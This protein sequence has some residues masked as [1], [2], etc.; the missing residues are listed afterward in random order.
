MIDFSELSLETFQ[1]LRAY[2]KEIVLYDENG[3]RVFEPS[4][5]RRFYLSGDNILVSI[6]EDGDNSAVK[7]YLSTNIQISEVL[8][9]VTVLRRIA[10]QFNVLFNVRKYNKKIEPKDFAT[11]AA[12]NEQKEYNMNIMEGLYGTSKSSYLKLEN[13]RMIVRHSARVKENMIG[14]RGRAIQSIFVE[15]AKGERFLFPVNVLSGARAMTQHVNHGGTFA[16]EVGQQI[17]R[18]AQDFSDLSKVAGHIGSNQKALPVQALNVRESIKSSAYDIRR[19]FERMCRDEASYVRESARITEGTA[20]NESKENIA[21]IVEALQTLLAIGGVSMDESALETV[22]KRVGFMEDMRPDSNTPDDAKDPDTGKAAQIV[23]PTQPVKPGQQTNQVG[24]GDQAD[25]DNGQDGDD[26][27]GHP[28]EDQDQENAGFH[29]SVAETAAVRAFDNWMSEFDP[30]TFFYEGKSFKRNKDEDVADKK[31]QDKQRRDDQKGKKER[32]DESSESLAQPV[33][34]ALQ[35]MGITVD[36]HMNDEGQVEISLKGTASS[37]QHDPNNR[38]VASP[39]N[40]SACIDKYFRSYRAAGHT[41]TQPVGGRFI[42]GEGKSYKRNKDDAVDD[43]KKQ[44]K[45]RR[46]DQKSKQE[47][48]DEA[49]SIAALEAKLKKLKKEHAD[50]DDFPSAR[51]ELADEIKTVEAALKA[52]KSL[53]EGKSFKRNEDEDVADKKKQDQDR[54]KARK[55]DSDPVEESANYFIP[56]VKSKFHIVAGGTGMSSQDDTLL[57]QSDDWNKAKQLASALV[58][59]YGDNVEIRSKSGKTLWAADYGNYDDVSSTGDIAEGKSF[60][61]NKDE[62]AAD[63]KKQD[64]Q[65]R[66]DQKNK[67]D[68]MDESIID[69]IDDD[70]E[71]DPD[72]VYDNEDEIIADV[73]RCIS[74]AR[75]N[76]GMMQQLAYKV[77]KGIRAL[78]LAGFS[79]MDV[80]DLEDP[81]VQAMGIS[82]SLEEGKSFKR[83]KDE[84]ADDKK[85]QDKQRRD[86]QRGKNE[87]VEEGKTF[88]RNKDEDAADK[89][90]QDQQKR[91]AAK[92]KKRADESSDIG[93]NDANKKVHP[94]ETQWHYKTLTD[95][96][97][98]PETKE[99]TGFVRKYKYQH[100]DGR[101]IVCTTGASADYWE[102]PKTK[103]SGYWGELENHVSQPAVQESPMKN[104]KRADEASDISFNDAKSQIKQVKQQLSKMSPFDKNYIATKAHLNKLEDRLARNGDDEVDEA[105][106]GPGYVDSSGANLRDSSALNEGDDILDPETNVTFT[107]MALGDTISGTV[108]SYHPEDQSY[109]IVGDDGEQYYVNKDDVDCETDESYVSNIGGYGGDTSDVVEADSTEEDE[110]SVLD[111]QGNFSV[112]KYMARLR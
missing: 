65:R 66:D 105:M 9:F 78:D 55:Q 103:K 39:Q 60:K 63:K 16:D 47:R 15:N 35:D 110:D 38:F 41:F 111:E 86:N 10:T 6:L 50:C 49:Q 95:A 58:T 28:G 17:I 4:D 7:V 22:A 90:K 81:T 53:E 109:T 56:Q 106:G 82:E 108:V 72:W 71:P 96:G 79:P 75:T 97:F 70:F 74:M 23:K 11:Q 46:D 32:T 43:K 84:D 27:D 24:D 99:A 20:L 102:D 112:A 67:Q 73:H 33:I 31:K 37:S 69:N 57:G 1:V 19:T 100:P 3:N 101:Q 104:M 83:N 94:V 85:K 18:M 64:K 80:V 13:A 48:T 52:A 2:G 77:Q 21:E 36:S 29:E 30:D 26:D 45:Q 40:I 76:P 44:D 93:F 89:K 91:D 59:K 88:K 61:R 51:H 14:G 25:G 8:E 42:I 34:K 54:R 5:A 12:V 92:N 68:R 62:D 98:N 107:D 87:P